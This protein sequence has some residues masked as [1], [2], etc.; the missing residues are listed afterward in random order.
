[1]LLSHRT[2]GTLPLKASVTKSLLVAGP[3][4]N[5]SANMQGIDCHG[6]PRGARAAVPLC[7]AVRPLRN[8]FAPDF[9]EHT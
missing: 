8:H 9:A 3:N 4:A 6:A 5:N 2:P 7:S 1:V